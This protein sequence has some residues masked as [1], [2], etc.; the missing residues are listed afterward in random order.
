M[1]TKLPTYLK[2]AEEAYLNFVKYHNENWE[3]LFDYQAI[4]IIIIIKL[5]KIK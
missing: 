5:S 4:L 3:L 1:Y 2:E